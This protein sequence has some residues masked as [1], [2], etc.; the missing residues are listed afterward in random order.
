MNSWLPENIAAQNF[1]RFWLAGLSL[2]VLLAVSN[3]VLMIEASPFGI[4]DHQSAGTAT[5]VDAIQNGW[6]QAGLLG[7]A[8]LSMA[9]DL[10]FIGVYFFGAVCG[11][12]LMRA[13][14]RI[15]VKRVG[16]LVIIGAVIFCVT[17]YIE[18]ILQMIQL[19]AMQ[20]SDHLAKIAASQGTIKVSGMLMTLAGLVG[21][22]IYDKLSA[23]KREN[24][25][26]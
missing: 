5:K 25:M 24:K 8:K 14:D 13:D 4:L 12:V 6:Q 23:S 16:A 15:A 17:D 11:G 10:I 7:F 1:M 20:G 19:F 9:V 2:A 22:I 21:K 3:F 18:T 26:E